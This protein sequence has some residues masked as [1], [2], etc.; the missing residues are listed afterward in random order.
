[1]DGEAAFSE[2]SGDVLAEAIGQVHALEAATRAT[3]LQLVTAL[4][5]SEAWR[6]DGATSVTAWLA[7]RLGLSHRTA[8]EWVRIAGALV[9]LPGV[10]AAFA[11]GLLSWDQLRA[12][13]SMATPA[14]DPE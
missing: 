9:E 13:V 10:A 2:W 1:M 12:V 5:R 14:T 6:D 3:M 8:A 7:Y 11:G 4:D